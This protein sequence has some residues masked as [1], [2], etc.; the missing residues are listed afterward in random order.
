MRI[1][2]NEIPQPKKKSVLKTGA[3][4][5]KKIISTAATLAKPF[6]PTPTTVSLS[7]AAR[8]LSESNKNDQAEQD[9]IQVA[10]LQK[11]QDNQSTKL[12]KKPGI[13]FIG[14][15]QLFSSTP[16][17]NGIKDMSNSMEDLNDGPNIARNNQV[18]E[19]IN[20]L[21]TESHTELDDHEDIQKKIFGSINQILKT[22]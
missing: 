6:G 10:E 17:G 8:L 21:R 18:S 19:V 14:G 16:F 22:A 20:E 13:F 11:N 3:K 12:I 2:K 7:L 15:F 9:S 5:A 4:V 1:E